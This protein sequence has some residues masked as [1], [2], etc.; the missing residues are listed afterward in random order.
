MKENQSH[1]PECALYAEWIAEALDGLLSAEQ[2]TALAAHRAQCPA[3]ARLYEQA[4]RGRQWAALLR[5]DPEPPADLLN[6]IL[7]ASGP[8][9]Q[10]HQTRLNSR[11]DPQLDP[12]PASLPQFPLWAQGARHNA[13]RRS[14]LA[15]LGFADGQQPG[16]ASPKQR[17]ASVHPLA[18]LLAAVPNW[19]AIAG[20]L[21]GAS[22]TRLLMTAATAIFSIAL[23][24]QL[25]GLHPEALRG[26][27]LDPIHLRGQFERRLTTASTPLLRYYDHLRV[28][29]EL[30]S[31]VRELRRS[32]GLI[33]PEEESRPQPAVPGESRRQPASD[34][35]SGLSSRL[36]RSQPQFFTVSDRRSTSWT[37]ASTTAA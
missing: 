35:D 37:P 22:A 32:N 13:G 4:G 19:S 5:P 31:R 24:L 2:E 14:S 6:R 7:A 10:P 8:T 23:S 28:V 1:A 15:L 9:A 25:A 21:S 20:R 3:C 36:E 27:N 34:G 30:E 26:A 11:I 16:A 12:R 18:R 29:N 33:A 17:I